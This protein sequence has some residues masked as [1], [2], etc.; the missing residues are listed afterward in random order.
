MYLAEN[1]EGYYKC[2]CTKVNTNM[3]HSPSYIILQ[4]NIVV[5]NE[6]HCLEAITCKRSHS[7]MP[8][9]VLSHR[10]EFLGQSPFCCLLELGHHKLHGLWQ[11]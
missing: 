5:H 10:R 8:I 2:M 7:D 11:V 9:N 4:Y 3:Y 6:V 1:E